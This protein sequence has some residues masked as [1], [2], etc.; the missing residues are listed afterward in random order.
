MTTDPTARPPRERIVLVFEDLGCIDLDGREVP[1]GV[2]LRQLLKTA[3]RRDRLRCLSFE[4]PKEDV[5]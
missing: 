2:R 1:L 5:P 4:K 3:L